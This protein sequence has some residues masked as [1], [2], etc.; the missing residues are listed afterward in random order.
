[1]L[2]P[3]FYDLPKEEVKLPKAKRAKFASEAEQLLGSVKGMDAKQG[4]E[5]FAKALDEI[6]EVLGYQFRIAVGAPRGM[7]GWKE[8]DFLI[9]TIYGYTAVEIDDMSFVHLGKQAEMTMEDGIRIAGLAD[10]G[11]N[12]RQIE[13][14]DNARLQNQED[15]AR[16]VKEL[17]K[18]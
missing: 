17:L 4:E 16:A 18:L 1:M 9:Q 6:G 12:V 2:E 14:V 10:M 5:R 8:L 11:V 7:P 13:H 3:Y 15:A